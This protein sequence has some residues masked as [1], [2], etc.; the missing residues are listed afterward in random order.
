M[1]DFDQSDRP[2][3]FLPPRI[4]PR[5]KRLELSRPF[6]A[7]PPINEEL[8]SPSTASVN[9]SALD[10]LTKAAPASALPFECDQPESNWLEPDFAAVLGNHDEGQDSLLDLA[11]LRHDRIASWVE[12]IAEAHRVTPA[13]SGQQAQVSHGSPRWA[14]A[15]AFWPRS[16]PVRWPGAVSIWGSVS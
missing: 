12:Q 9:V 14:S 1:S 11:L 7:E 2:A 15:S 6:T 5:F 13:S 10:D 4:P 16:L 3:P 8:S